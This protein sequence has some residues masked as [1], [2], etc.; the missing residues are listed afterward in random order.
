MDTTVQQTGLVHRLRTW[1]PHL[2]LTTSIG[3][4]SDQA[5]A[6]AAPAKWCRRQWKERLDAAGRQREGGQREGS[7]REGSRRTASEHYLKLA[8]T[9]LRRQPLQ[10]A[11]PTPLGRIWLDKGRGF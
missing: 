11:A 4:T 2:V 9:V 1:P 7:E 5:S 3:I 6:P 8:E 10:P